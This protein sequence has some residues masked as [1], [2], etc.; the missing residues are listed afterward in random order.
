MMLTLTIILLMLMLFALIVYL[1]CTVAVSL[2]N[3]Y[4]DYK[5]NK[6]H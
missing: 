1:I 4:D 6:R 5:V 3:R 2:V